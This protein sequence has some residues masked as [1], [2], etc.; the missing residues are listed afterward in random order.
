MPAST[1]PRM[2]C[3]SLGSV[4]RE[5]RSRS[6]RGIRRR[7]MVVR[8]TAARHDARHDDGKGPAN[9]IRRRGRHGTVV[10]PTI[11]QAMRSVFAQQFPGRIQM[12]VGIDRWEGPRA[13][14]EQLIAECP[15][16][17]AVTTLD[18]GY[19][20]SKRHG[21]LYPSSYGGALK[22]IL[23]YAAN[24]RYVTYL[25]DDNWYAPTHLAS[26]LRRRRRQG[27]GVRAAH[28]RRCGDRTSSSVRT[29]GN[30]SVPGAVSTRR[31]RAGSSTRTATSSTSSPAPNVFLEWANTRFQ[32]GT[33]GDRQ[34]LQ[35]LLGRPWGT[36]GAHSV[37]YRHSLAGL[38]YYLLWR[39]KCAGVDL[40]PLHARG[41]GPARVG[42]A[43]NAPPSTARTGTRS[44]SRWTPRRS[45]AAPGVACRPALQAR[46]PLSTHIR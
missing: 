25:D 6:A 26:M 17:V 16:H 34:I 2:V 3:F 45:E 23:S 42:V 46:E 31:R 21:G 35:R 15:S 20:T 4:V 5:T 29:R 40:A 1:R 19:S 24:S 14:L 27:L 9:A 43:S 30:R 33:G 37:F 44:A 22:T 41:C 39:F 7:A 8:N 13:L 12:L 28:F 18:L 32:G 11:A 38:P 36:N 10:R